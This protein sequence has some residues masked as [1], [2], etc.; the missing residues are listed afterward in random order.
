MDEVEL[1]GIAQK[2]LLKIF[3]VLSGSR[4]KDLLRSAAASISSFLVRFAV[5]VPHLRVTNPSH[6]FDQKSRIVQ[7]PHLRVMN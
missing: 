2:V 5:Q 7:V 6:V 1:N 3:F 4:N